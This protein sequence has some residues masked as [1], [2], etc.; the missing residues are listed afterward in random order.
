MKYLILTLALLSTACVGTRVREN[1]LMPP[2]AM[3]YENVRADIERG[4]SAGLD[5]GT[6]SA[7][8]AEQHR[9]N[10][11]ALGAALD[12]GDLAKL[13]RAPRF[14]PELEQLALDGIQDRIDDGEMTE[15]VAL[16]LRLRVQNVRDGI[17][18]LLGVRPIAEVESEWGR[19][20]RLAAQ[21]VV[22]VYVVNQTAYAR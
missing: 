18:T 3:A 19:N 22:P 15:P 5:D 10:A 9:S 4:I 21:G 6:I 2:V 12:S 14:S 8:A 7:V 1:A 16:S 20:R 11:A 17:D 13:R